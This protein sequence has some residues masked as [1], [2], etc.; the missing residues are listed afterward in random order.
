MDDVERLVR[1]LYVEAATA[2]GDDVHAI[3]RYVA[4][5]VAS[6][7]HDDRRRIENGTEKVLAFQAPARR[8]DHS[9]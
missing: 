2:C 3:V 6:M 8:P 7:S 9:H 4:D 5:R 1:D